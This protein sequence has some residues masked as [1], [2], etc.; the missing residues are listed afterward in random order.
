MYH[1]LLIVNFDQIITKWINSITI[2]KDYTY[3]AIQLYKYLI[4]QYNLSRFNCNPILFDK[5][6][7]ICI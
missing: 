3:T 6:K 5:K 2:I 4:L 1:I 7:K